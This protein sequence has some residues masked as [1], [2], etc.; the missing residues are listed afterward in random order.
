[1]RPSEESAVGDVVSGDPKQDPIA[2]TAT[3]IGF[4][5]EPE[6]EEEEPLAA[7]K[8]EEETELM[9]ASQLL[10]VRVSELEERGLRIRV[11][12]G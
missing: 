11:I 3:E 1:M 4:R 5:P 2:R 8:P 9:E 10:T 12:R 7:E 6:E